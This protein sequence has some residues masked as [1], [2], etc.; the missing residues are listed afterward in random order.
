MSL[1]I[2]K[3]VLVEKRLRQLLSCSTDLEGLED[4]KV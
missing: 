4:V 3:L 1:G 2:G